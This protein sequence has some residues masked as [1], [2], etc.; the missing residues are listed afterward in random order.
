M[1][2]A[3][4][5]VTAVLGLAAC[6][7]TRFDQLYDAGRYDAAIAEFAADSSLRADERTL[8]RAAV[9][10]ATPNHAAYEPAQARALLE[11]LLRRF[12]AGAYHLQAR[13]LATSLASTHQ[14]ATDASRIESQLTA[15][16]ERIASLEHRVALQEAVHDELATGTVALRDTLQRVQLQLQVREGQMRALQEELRGLKQIDLAPIV[17]DT[18]RTR[19]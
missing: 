13:A 4:L 10:R 8:F 16:R 11:D 12:P 18:T 17:P 9:A 3:L 19:R 7:S 5:C 1:R 15:L 2:H 14:L 6:A